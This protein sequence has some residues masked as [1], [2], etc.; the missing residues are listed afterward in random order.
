MP[1]LLEIG[2]QR[3]GVDFDALSFCAL[4]LQAASIVKN[5][6]NIPEV[7]PQHESGQCVVMNVLGARAV[8]V[9]GRKEGRKKERN[10]PR[11]NTKEHKEKGCC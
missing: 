7:L 6:T 10:S 2:S 11:K 1:E 3:E 9:G 4:C 5:L 8:C